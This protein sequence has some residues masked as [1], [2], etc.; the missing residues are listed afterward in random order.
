M[1]ANGQLLLPRQ[2]EHGH[3]PVLQKLD[4]DS[5]TGTMGKALGHPVLGWRVTNTRLQQHALKRRRRQ[6]GSTPTPVVTI[7]PPTSTDAT[8]DTTDADSMTH[9]VGVV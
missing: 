7:A 5:G 3:F 9:K 1:G 6:A 8:V 2:V 4:D